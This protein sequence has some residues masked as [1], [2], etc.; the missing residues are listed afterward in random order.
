MSG[1]FHQTTSMKR[2]LVFTGWYPSP[3]NKANYPFVSQQVKMLMHWLPLFTNQEWRFI[4]WNEEL[5]VDIFNHIFRKRSINTRWSDGEVSV[6]RRRGLILSH[7]LPFDQYFMLMPGMR[8]TYKKITEELGGDPDFVWTVTLSSAIMWERFARDQKLS[9]PFLLQEHSVPL[10]MHLKSRFNRTRAPQSIVNS[11]ALIVV[12]DRQR[13]EFQNLVSG[14]QPLVIWNAVD[15]S[16]LAEGKGCAKNDVFTFLFTGRISKQKGL[17]RLVKAAEHLKNAGFEFKILIVGEGELE[18]H[19]KS[20]IRNLDLE[21]YFEWKGRKTAAEIGELM[22]NCHAFVLP[23]LYEN[24]P[25]ALLEA[26]VKGLPCVVTE[27]NASEKVL[28]PEN[29]IAVADNGEGKELGMAMEQMV[30]NF[31]SYDQR[32][33]RKRSIAHFSSEVFAKN[34]LSVFQKVLG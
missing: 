31:E 25:V 22:D 14:I 3:G 2:V 13:A 12:A 23:S 34:M 11:S 21:T 19:I 7:R 24:C 17:F 10:S 27:N 30:M 28:L 5:S 18:D 1:Q 20:M 8:K 6:Y 9:F 16:F 33:I 29:G 4:V 32:L 26:Q 15:D